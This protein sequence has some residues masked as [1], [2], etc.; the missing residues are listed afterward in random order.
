MLN[1]PQGARRA[2]RIVFPF[3]LIPL[4]VWIGTV[5]ADERRHLFVSLAVAILSLLLFYAGIEERIVGSRRAVLVAI[6]VALSVVGRLIPIFKPVTAI[7]VIG[8]LYLGGEAGFLIGSLS[9][10]LSNF[11]FGQGPWT[12]FQMLAWG[13]IGLLAGYL[14]KPLGKSRV[15]LLLY[16]VLSG[17]LFSMIMDLWTVLW[18]NGRIDLSLYRAALVT[19]LPH[20]V[21]YALSNFV[22]LWVLAKPLGDKLARIKLKYG[23]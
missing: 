23:I 13:M 6:L 14:A 9:A 22:F 15:L 11:T 3:L 5:V 2:I 18:A 8:A 16:G 7:T 12:P 20:T 1:L 21:L 17:A 4:T 10:L 19:A